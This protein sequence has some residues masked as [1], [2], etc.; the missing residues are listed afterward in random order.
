[1][2]VLLG[3]PVNESTVTMAETIARQ[4][5]QNVTG[6]IIHDTPKSDILS[7]KH[8]I[9]VHIVE[10]GP[11]VFAQLTAERTYSLECAALTPL[12]IAPSHGWIWTPSNT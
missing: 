2:Q 5:R 7:L 4:G 6:N 12:K 10:I 11:P 8:V 3:D 9:G 1:M